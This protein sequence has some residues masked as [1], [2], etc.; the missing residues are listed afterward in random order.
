MQLSWIGTVLNRKGWPRAPG[1]TI[2][3]FRANSCLSGTFLERRNMT[4]LSDLRPVWAV[5]SAA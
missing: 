5:C 1:P 2:A 3:G 4:D